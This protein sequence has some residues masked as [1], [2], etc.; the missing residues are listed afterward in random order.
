MSIQ[1][2]MQQ[3][4]P[5]IVARIELQLLYHLLRICVLSNPHST[6]RCFAGQEGGLARIDR[7]RFERLRVRADSAFRVVLDVELTG[8][9][10]L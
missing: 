8:N 5:G 2:K 10:S 9:S 3:R 7:F 1:N 6:M 4:Q